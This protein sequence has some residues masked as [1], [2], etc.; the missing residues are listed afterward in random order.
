MR[1][2]AAAALLAAFAALPA[3]AEVKL[4]PY[5]PLGGRYVFYLVADSASE[6][7]SAA[8]QGAWA[9]AKLEAKPYCRYASGWAPCSEGGAGGVSDGD[10]GDITVGSAGAAWSIDADSVAL[11]ADTTGG[12][13]ASVSEGG[14]A[15][16][17]TALASDPS[18]CPSGQYAT[19]VDASAN[20]TCSQVAY[21]QIS[22][23]P[24]AGP[25]AYRLSG[26]SDLSSS[27]T[28]AVNVSGIGWAIGVGALQTFSCVIVHQGTATSGPRFGFSGPGSPARVNIRYDRAT[29][30]SAATQSESTA[31]SAT[32]QTAAITSSGNTTVL[33]SRFHGSILNGTNA[34]TVQLHL[35]SSTSGQAVKVYRGSSCLV[36]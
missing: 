5:R 4:E 1:R 18:G 22:G 14:A 11:G 20:L 29:S 17:A 15:T 35:T 3:I 28:S 19:E 21:S 8:P 34:G 23:A 6:L 12:Y 32:A 7:Q 10:K 2:I 27:S 33:T 31:F 16:T 24:A 26:A 25:A 9:W 13:A 36:W 30:A